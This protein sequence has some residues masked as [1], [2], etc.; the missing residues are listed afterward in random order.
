MACF[1]RCIG[2]LQKDPP[3]RRASQTSAAQR[4]QIRMTAKWQG[5]PKRWRVR[6]KST[7]DMTVTLGCHD[8]EK[9]A[10][11]EA[12]KLLKAGFYRDVTVERIESAAGSDAK[13]AKDA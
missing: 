8:T 1:A 9:A 6:G 13:D 12:E 11:A 4:A 10:Q 7:D 3:A 5:E 2:T